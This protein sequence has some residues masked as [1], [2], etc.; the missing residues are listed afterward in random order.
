M[1]ICCLKCKKKTDTLNS[2]KT[3]TKNGRKQL[4][5]QCKICNTNRNQFV[6]N[7]DKLKEVYYDSK[8]DF[9]GINDL[10][11]KTGKIQKEVEGFLHQ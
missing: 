4:K 1:E 6:K 2:N 5:G 11:R 10:Q 3:T 8:Q 9:S 7:D